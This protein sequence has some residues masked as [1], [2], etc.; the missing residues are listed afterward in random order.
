[1]RIIDTAK[2]KLSFAPEKYI[3]N[4]TRYGNTS[5]ACIPMMLDEPTAPESLKMATISRWRRWR[6]LVQRQRG[7]EM[8]CGVRSMA[9]ETIKALADYK[10][11][12]ENSI[13]RET[14]FESMGI[15]SWTRWIW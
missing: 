11:I 6:R 3:Y 8:E 15:D 5:A 7:A 14:T 2:A 12:D 13:T 9:L 10:H 1:M 4:I